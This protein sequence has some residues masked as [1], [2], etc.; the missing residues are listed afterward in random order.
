MFVV[1]TVYL[2][3]YV[4]LSATPPRPLLIPLPSTS[5]RPQARRFSPTTLLVKGKRL[6]SVMYC[7]ARVIL[8]IV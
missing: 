8:V 2:R 5:N 4:C 7:L 1:F 3:H 6:I